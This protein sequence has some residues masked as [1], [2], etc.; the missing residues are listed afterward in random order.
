[1]DCNFN[2]TAT[3]LKLSCSTLN[4]AFE[5][6]GLTRR[7][8]SSAYDFSRFVLLLKSSFSQA[9][10]LL[11]AGLRFR[12]FSLPLSAMKILRSRG[13]FFDD[14]FQP[15]SLKFMNESLSQNELTSLINIVRTE[16]IVSSSLKE[17]VVNDD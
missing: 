12:K 5:I 17:H 4:L 8:S 3:S 11:A 13:K 15:K 14:D 16:V 10:I 6:V 7:Q 9:G 1:M 2:R